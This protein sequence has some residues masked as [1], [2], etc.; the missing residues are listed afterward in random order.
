[1]VEVTVVGGETGYTQQVEVG[2]HRLTADEPAEFGGSAT[3]PSPYEYLLVA[4]GSCT[5]MTLRMYADRKG[6]PLKGVTVRLRHDKIHAKDCE[7]CE[8]RIGKVDCIE[9]EIELEGDLDDAAR[10][11]LLQIADKCPVHRTLTRE[12]VIRTS[13]KS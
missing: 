5:S 13:G 1:M 3:G 4:L 11:R 8:T 2:P 12:V 9:R 7:E 10:E 6:I